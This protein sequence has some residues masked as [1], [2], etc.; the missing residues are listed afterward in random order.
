LRL[1]GQETSQSGVFIG[2]LYY[3]LLIPFY[4]IFNMDP[5][6]GIFLV[7]LIGAASIISIY[8]VFQ[9]VFNDKVAIISSLI[10]AVNFNV[11]FTDREV[12]P[13]TPVHLW[14]IWYLYSLYLIIKG[15]HKT[16]LIL[17]GILVGFVWH[18]NL[19]LLVTLPAALVAL[20][21][22]RKK[23][24]VKNLMFGFVASILGILPFVL[25]EMRHNFQQINAIFKSSVETSEGITKFNRLIEILSTNTKELTWGPFLNIKF[26]YALYLI[27]AAIVIIYVKK[28]IDRKLFSLL[29]IWIISYV[30]FFSTNSLILSEYYLNGLTIIWILCLAV[31]LSSFSKK[32]FWMPIIILGIYSILNINR[33]VGINVNRSGYLER[34]SIVHFIKTDAAEH[35][36]PCVS[37]S[38]I[39]EPGYNLGYRYLFWIEKMHVNNP[40]SM[41]PVYTIVFPHSMVDKIDKSFGALGLI[42]PDYKI[43]NKEGVA[44]SCEGENSNVTDPMFGFLN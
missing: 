16:G 43:Y 36:F 5:I 25:F 42:F 13:T 39:T 7:T 33:V 28:L 31:V 2:P 18:I 44:K 17:L 1:I 21:Y 4:L 34:K 32:Y 37:I 14:T 35:G 9:K 20:F 29:L 6:G 19:G 15:K 10:Y 38:Y 41:S 22:S 11:V 23:I 26:E 24:K 27:I 40:S 12:V 30:A 8:W 3:Y